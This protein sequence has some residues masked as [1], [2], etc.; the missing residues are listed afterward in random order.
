MRPTSRLEEG[1]AGRLYPSTEQ[2]DRRQ[3]GVLPEAPLLTGL[4]PRPCQRG[5]GEGLRGPTGDSKA[6]GTAN[7][8][9]LL[10]PEAA[11]VRR[12]DAT[13]IELELLATLARR[14]AHSRGNLATPSSRRP[15]P[16]QAPPS[17]LVPAAKPL[18][19]SPK[20]GSASSGDGPARLPGI[21]LTPRPTAL[22]PDHYRE[23]MPTVHSIPMPL[24]HANLAGRPCRHRRP[25]TQEPLPHS[26]PRMVPLTLVATQ[27]FLPRG[28]GTKPVPR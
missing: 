25:A 27:W 17:P 8:I 6:G 14:R 26:R 5:H 12:A 22:H 24:G 1:H 16:V 20:K 19:P 9:R 28:G 7:W 10:L 21:C 13:A 15:A 18:W 23:S 11:Q 3:R 2:R 4:W